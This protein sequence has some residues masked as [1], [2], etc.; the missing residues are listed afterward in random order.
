MLPGLFFIQPTPAFPLGH[1][2]GSF[3]PAVFEAVYPGA[4]LHGVP[5]RFS[6]KGA[7]AF[8]VSRFYPVETIRGGKAF[9][10]GVVLFVWSGHAPGKEDDKNY[11]RVFHEKITPLR[12]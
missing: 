1:V 6:Q 8:F 10:G 2:G 9:R 3:I 7:R 4:F 5:A 11:N 12:K